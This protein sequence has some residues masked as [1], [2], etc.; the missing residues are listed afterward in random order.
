MSRSVIPNLRVIGTH[1]VRVGHF[2]TSFSTSP[3]RQLVPAGIGQRIPVVCKSCSSN[4][5]QLCSLVFL[6]EL[7]RRTCAPTD[8][9]VT[10][11]DDSPYPNVAMHSEIGVVPIKYNGN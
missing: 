8:E 4:I 1:C 9:D 11:S 10:L 3:D 7:L 5:T 6:S 2:T